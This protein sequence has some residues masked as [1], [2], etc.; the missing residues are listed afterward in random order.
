[1]SVAAEGEGGVKDDWQVS[2]LGNGLVVLFTKTG[3]PGA[4]LLMSHLGALLPWQS[5]SKLM[6]TFSLPGEAGDAA[7]FSAL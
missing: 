3:H 2:G 5:G 4:P 7:L 6:E 1:M